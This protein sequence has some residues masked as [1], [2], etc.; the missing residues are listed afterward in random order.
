MTQ[1]DLTFAIQLRE[2]E[3]QRA[4]NSHAQERARLLAEL[5]NVRGQLHRVE[6][7]MQTQLEEVPS[8]SEPPPPTLTA[9]FTTKRIVPPFLSSWKDSTLTSFVA[10]R[11]GESCAMFLSFHAANSRRPLSRHAPGTKRGKQRG[12]GGEKR[13]RVWS[14]ASG[15]S[16]SEWPTCSKYCC[17]CVFF[18]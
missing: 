9:T 15:C 17:F 3:L 10:T 14:V 2:E 13:K 5:G 11:C 16:S 1:R 6:A 4:K 7:A 12:R 8:P 18:V